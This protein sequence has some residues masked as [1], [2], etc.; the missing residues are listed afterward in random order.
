M[1]LTIIELEN[2]TKYLVLSF[3]AA[4][5]PDSFSCNLS[6]NFV[7]PL[8]DNLQK[9]LPNVTTSHFSCNA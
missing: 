4:V 7:A 9:T 3:K 1:R 5:T 2:P 8:P 6:R